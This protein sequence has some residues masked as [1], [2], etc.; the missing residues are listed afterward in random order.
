M[1]RARDDLAMQCRMLVK[2]NY[3]AEICKQQMRMLVET[4]SEEIDQNND[5][6]TSMVDSFR[7]IH[8][9][10]RFRV[11]VLA[12][13]AAN[14][15][16]HFGKHANFAIFTC[17][18][19]AISNSRVVVV[20]GKTATPNI[21]KNESNMTSQSDLV[22]DWLTS[23][24]MIHTIRDAACGL[25]DA[26]KK[27]RGDKSGYM[28]RALLKTAENSFIKLMETTQSAFPMYKLEP[29]SIRDRSSLCRMIGGG[30]E[31]ILR[32]PALRDAVNLY[33]VE[34][35]FSALQRHILGFTERLHTG[36]LEK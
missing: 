21:S 31:K 13:I 24:H 27:N 7:L 22:A 30:L 34:H 3:N 28:S 12:V 18:D 6:K 29:A 15:L 14:R 35:S 10:I 20:A 25:V 17:N 1:I 19:S 4:L 26:L 33:S 16:V 5:D 32:Q 36:E 9:L 2:A 8:P 11:A 23:S